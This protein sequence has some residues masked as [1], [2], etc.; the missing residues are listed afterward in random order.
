MYFRPGASITRQIVAITQM[1]WSAMFVH[2][3]GG[4]IETHFHIFVSLAFL[5]FYKD[6]RV[7]ISATL[8]VVIDHLIL[9]LYWPE[10]IYGTANPEWWRFFEHAA[11]VLFEDIVLW[12][13]C[14][15]ALQ[16]MRTLAEREAS[17]ESAMHS[18][19]AQVTERTSEL[20]TSADRYKALIENT[21]AIPWE[22][23]RLT[24]EIV[25]LA[26][27]GKSTFGL[28]E[29]TQP[30]SNCLADLFHPDDRDVFRSFVLNRG[31]ILGEGDT[32]L[33]TRVIN[34]NE[35]VHVRS[36]V[37]QQAGAEPAESVYGISLNITQQRKLEQEL[38]QAQ[39]LESIGQLAAGIAH[40]I[41]TPTQFI[42][43]NIRFLQESVGD[44]LAGLDHSG[45][46]G[47]SKDA[48][49]APGGADL[50]YLKIEI[51]KA[52]AQSLE[53][54]ERISKI[55]GAMK[56]F[57]HPAIERTP[58]D[59]NRAIASTILVASNEWKYVAELHTEFDPALPLATVMPGA[60]NQV[61]LNILVNAAHAIAAL[62]KNT[63]S[64]KGV[65]NVRTARVGP[66]VEIRIRDSGCGI[67]PSVQDRIFDPFFTTK[68]VGKGTGQG[69]AIAHDVIVKRHKGTLTVESAVNEG[70]TFI[71]RIPLDDTSPRPAA[72]A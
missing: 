65:I 38:S 28:P 10:S 60:F 68:P 51:P 57:S 11:W 66:W 33:D 58:L 3:T 39:K 6:P 46:P 23:N 64:V 13:G 70:T 41:N 16:E 55:V 36:F 50:D 47:E 40:E 4:R 44:I 67:P 63:P 22:A 19:E 5:S 59:L 9:G 32:H 21:S 18:V 24:S 17:L 12:F 7:F 49:Q 2:L 27:Q 52:F 61:I 35:I 15:K 29:G 8:T 72:A 71:I 31:N 48:A 30:S 42:S 45:L 1:L 54:L 56:E 25:Y 53:G 69:L 37:A 43:D 62:P 14:A 34:N 20:R 26:P